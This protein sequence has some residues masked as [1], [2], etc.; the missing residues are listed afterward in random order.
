[1]LTFTFGRNFVCRC[2]AFGG[3]FFCRT[4]LPSTM[5]AYDRP[6]DYSSGVDALR[7]AETWGEYQVICSPNAPQSITS[8]TAL[9]TQ[10]KSIRITTQ[11]ISISIVTSGR[12][13]TKNSSEA[14]ERLF[15]PV[16]QSLVL[17][18]QRRYGLCLPS[19][20]YRSTAGCGVKREVLTYAL[21]LDSVNY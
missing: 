14:V 17:A 12:D 13:Q 1:M 2:N 3:N 18:N 6:T 7:P 19:C 21:R 5:T 11:I 8:L 16:N 9:L 20:G 10:F 15:I 4:Q